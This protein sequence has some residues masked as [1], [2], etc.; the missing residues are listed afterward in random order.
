MTRRCTQIVFFLILTLVSLVSACSDPAESGP[1]SGSGGLDTS[2]GEPDSSTEPDTLIPTN[3]CDGLA[4]GESRCTGGEIESCR[5]GKLVSNACVAG[6][7]CSAGTCVCD[8]ASDGV[9][10]SQCS[11]DPDCDPNCVPQCSNRE[12]GADGCGGTCGSGCTVS[13]NCADGMCESV[14]GICSDTCGPTSSPGDWADD[15]E[16]DDTGEGGG[17]YC[18]YGT[19]CTDCEA[20]PIPP[21]SCSVNYNAD[22]PAGERC[23]CSEDTGDCFCESGTRGTGALGDACSSQHDCATG[24]CVD[25][26][27]SKRCGGGADCGGDVPVCQSIIG[28][29]VAGECTP[30]CGG[31][32]CGDDGCGGSCG[33]CAA[34]KVC[35]SGTCQPGSTS[36]FAC[37]GS[38]DCQTGESCCVSQSGASSCTAVGSNLDVQCRQEAS[39]GT[40]RYIGCDDDSDCPG[41]VCCANLDSTFCADS[42]S[43]S[44][45]CNLSDNNCATSERC[46]E[47][48]D[49]L[50]LSDSPEAGVCFPTTMQCP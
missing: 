27:C 18:T 19:D 23:D 42:C 21:V 32:T 4:E 3:D 29:C 44:E 20:R 38:A 24:I 34:S 35:V 11:D 1:D 48:R 28:Y 43:F 16:C 2:V 5:S 7:N 26:Q 47:F 10:P 40:Y 13:E 6:K 25:D 49:S 37:P 36:A 15:G 14:D 46:C 22:C 17:G 30:D 33:S 45:G 41:Q 9:C 12:C 31:R 39:E 8:N 50:I